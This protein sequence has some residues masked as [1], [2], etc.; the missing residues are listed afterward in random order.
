MYPIS[1]AA[2]EIPLVVEEKQKP[3]QDLA[4]QVMEQSLP[5]NRR[6]IYL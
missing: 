5:D 4:H 6:E 1:R 2:I 3:E